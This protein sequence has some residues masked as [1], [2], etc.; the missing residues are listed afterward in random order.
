MEIM[1]HFTITTCCPVV[2]VD[3][4]SV[5]P[6]RLVY[7]PVG[8]ASS[9]LSYERCTVFIVSLIGKISRGKVM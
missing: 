8:Y 5:F 9:L 7:F 6:H 4:W 1:K 2:A 3:N